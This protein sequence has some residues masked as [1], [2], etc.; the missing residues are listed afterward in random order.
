MKLFGHP[1]SLNTRK[2]LLMFAEKGHEPEFSLVALPAGEHLQPAHLAR[3]PFGKVPVLEDGGTVVYESAAITAHLERTLAGPRLTP[4][5]ARGAAAVDQWVAVADNYLARHAD[6]VIVDR[7][8]GP[9]LG[10]VSDPDKS[11][12]EA[13]ALDRPLDVL[14]ER[15]QAAPYLA[16][17]SFTRA[18]I[19]W[20]P[21]ID[22]LL[23]AGE[24]ERVEPRA[25]IMAWWN[26]VSARPSFRSVAME[27][28]QP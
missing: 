1:W 27:G 19:H 28:P 26:R 15:L 20:M 9:Y 24:R 17:D 14:S 3:H 12:R 23:R 13:E 10:L 4:S 22:Y 25:P 18:D 21:Y 7:L 16:G 8:F 5:D 11:N 2:V 6:V